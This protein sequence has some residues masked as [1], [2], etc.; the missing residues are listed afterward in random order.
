MDS[1]PSDRQ[2]YHCVM[3]PLNTVA[4]AGDAAWF[5][6]AA[7]ATKKYV[8]AVLWQVRAGSSHCTALQVSGIRWSS[9]QCLASPILAARWFYGLSVRESFGLVNLL[10]FLNFSYSF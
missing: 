4:F 1:C 5:A 10:W 2:P 3:L 8:V 6:S 9:S 7:D